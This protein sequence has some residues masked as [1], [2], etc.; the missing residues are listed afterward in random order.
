M[1]VVVSP[2]ATVRRLLPLVSARPFIYIYLFSVFLSAPV[3]VV[4]RPPGVSSTSAPLCYLDGLVI[5]LSARG[6]IV[7]HFSSSLP[8]PFV[9]GPCRRGCPS[10]V[11]PG[12]V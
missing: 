10:P 2:P 7:I 8:L 9:M 1:G 5:V 6:L 4:G 12:S 3:V 11:S